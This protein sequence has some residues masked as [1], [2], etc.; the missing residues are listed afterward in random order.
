MCLTAGNKDAYRTNNSF[1]MYTAKCPICRSKPFITIN[2]K[3]YHHNYDDLQGKI[4]FEYFKLNKQII[5][6]ECISFCARCRAIYRAKFFDEDEIEQI[7][8][9]LYISLEESIRDDTGYVYNNQAFL[10]GCS[11]KMYNIVTELE[12]RFKIKIKDVFDIGGRDGFRLKH[13]AGAGYNCRVFDPID[14]DVCDPK[15]SKE[16]LWSKQISKDE[17]ADIIFLCNVL[18]HCT[19]PYSIIMDCYDHL[20]DGG[21]L[22]IELPSDI[23]TVCDWMLFGMWHRQNLA[24]DSTHYIFYSRK[25]VSLLFDSLRFR[26]IQFTY[27]ILPECNVNVMEMIG[28]KENG[29]RKTSPYL[30]LDFDLIDSGYFPRLLRRI[31]R[32]LKRSFFLISIIMI[33]KELM[34]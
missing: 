23:E 2:K 21:L 17:K 27:S 13:L 34:Q 20:Y 9:G 19:D 29:M 31:A 4:A 1:M 7:Y 3:I 18:E 14:C 6:E 32:K 26:V 10:D 22:Y 24:I 11:Q 25:S 8:N 16:R 28:R 30:S 5:P 12:S 33:C 15:I